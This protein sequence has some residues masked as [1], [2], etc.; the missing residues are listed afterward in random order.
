MIN[1][2]LDSLIDESWI[3]VPDPSIVFHRISEQESFD[4]SMTPNGSI[5]CCEIMSSPSRNF[6]DTSDDELLSLTISGLKKMGFNNTKVIGHRIIRLPKSYPVFYKNY[7]QNLE[8]ILIQ[9]DNLSNFKTIGRNGAF[10]YIGTLDAMDIGY[11]FAEWL[12]KGIKNNWYSERIR[13][14]HYKILD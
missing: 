3:F 4:A 10:N 8:K 12:T 2:D 5:I 1:I 14:A 9:I 11:G 13:T 7:Y 6:S